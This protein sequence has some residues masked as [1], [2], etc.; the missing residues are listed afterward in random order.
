L[1][2]VRRAEHRFKCLVGEPQQ[3][4]TDARKAIFSIFVLLLTVAPLILIPA[5]AVF[6]GFSIFVTVAAFVGVCLAGC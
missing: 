6:G 4:I 5:A 2:R 3:F 1:L